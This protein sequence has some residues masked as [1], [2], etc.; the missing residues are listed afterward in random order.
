[1]DAGFLRKGAGGGLAVLQ[2][3]SRQAKSG[4]FSADWAGGDGA[5]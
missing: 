3:G 4:P 2:K 5:M 1:M